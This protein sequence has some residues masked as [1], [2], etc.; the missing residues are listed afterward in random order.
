MDRHKGWNLN[1][2]RFTEKGVSDGR[3]AD[4]V[5]GNRNNHL[6][7]LQQELTVRISVV[8]IAAR[9]LGA[10]TEGLAGFITQKW[11]DLAVR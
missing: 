2:E 8:L 4:S 7:W 3:V 5:P 11:Q 6:R 9:M 1:K 10:D